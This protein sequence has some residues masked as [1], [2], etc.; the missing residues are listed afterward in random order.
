MTR[1]DTNF[2][3]ETLN[4]RQAYD[5]YFNGKLVP[6]RINW[7]NGDEVGVSY[8]NGNGNVLKVTDLVYKKRRFKLK[9]KNNRDS[10]NNRKIRNN[11]D[12]KMIYEIRLLIKVSTRKNMIMGGDIVLEKIF[13]NSGLEYEQ[14][15][16]YDVNDNPLKNK[17]M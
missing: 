2:D 14:G 4:K 15:E 6:V 5:T 8:N 9:K 10:L 1:P 12:K 13:K 16:I 7:R 17:E 11:R 3:T